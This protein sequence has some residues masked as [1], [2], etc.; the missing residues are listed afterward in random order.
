MAKW[1]QF[2]YPEGA[3]WRD[4]PEN[5]IRY[6]LAIFRSISPDDL[7]RAFDDEEILDSYFELIGAGFLVIEIQE[8]KKGVRTRVSYP[9]G[10]FLLDGFQDEFLSEAVH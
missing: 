9:K 6:T 8:R 5:E 1:F 2:A 3:D 4:L 7:N 10:P